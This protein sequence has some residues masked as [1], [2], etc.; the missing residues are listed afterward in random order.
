MLHENSLR[1]WRPMKKKLLREST[2][3]NKSVST[4]E[5]IFISKGII[6]K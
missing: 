3:M 6:I 4:Q 2:K 5:M 1:Q